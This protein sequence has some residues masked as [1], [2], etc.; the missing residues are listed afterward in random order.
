MTDPLGQSQ[1]LPYLV[2]LSNKGVKISLI[3]FEKEERFV[4]GQLAIKTIVEQNSI[5]W[6]PQRYTKN[7][8]LLSTVRDIA[9]FYNVVDKLVLN[10]DVDLIHCRSYIAG[11]VGLRMKR[12]YEIPFLFDMRGFWADERIDGGIWR[13]EN[14]LFR[15]VYN[16]FKKKEKQ[17]LTES[18]ATISLT[19]VGK[20]EIESWKLENLSPIEIIPCCTDENLFN[21]QSVNS[22][23]VNKFKQEHE[24]SSN[25]FILSYLGSIG[26]WYLLNEMLDFVK[27]LFDQNANAKMLFITQESEDNILRLAKEKGIDKNRIVIIAAQR[28]EVQNLL[29]ISSASL[30][31][32]KPAYSKKASSPT[33]MGEIMNLGIPVICNSGVGDTDVVM[34]EVEP[35]LLVKEFSEV[36]YSRVLTEIEKVGYKSEEFKS[37]LK[38]TATK[39]FSLEKGIEKYF[40][41]YQSIKTG[42]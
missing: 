7:P 6:F 32:I 25:D 24:I 38:Q 29:S 17:F 23:W 28:N 27:V 40:Q 36:E 20:E 2:G 34:N 39:Y 41:I 4:S 3:S 31:F 8:P 1:V 11:L 13:L 16:Y 10:G 30:F 21:E 22:E 12:K 14:P 42:K 18:F 5:N 19:Q 9:K 37:Q 26:T 15:R 35:K 33:K